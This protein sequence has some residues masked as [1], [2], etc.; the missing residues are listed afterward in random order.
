MEFEKDLQIAV[1]GAGHGGK[2]MAADLAARGYAVRLYNRSYPNIEEIA[3]R[4]GIELTLEDGQ[5]CSGSLQLVTSGSIGTLIAI[6]D[7]KA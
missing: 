4:G 7:K 5:R 6:G 2:A 3:V 1:I